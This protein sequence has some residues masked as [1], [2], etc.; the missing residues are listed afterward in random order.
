MYLKLICLRKA[1]FTTSLEDSYGVM[2]QA[3]NPYEELGCATWFVRAQAE[4]A[5]LHRL[6]AWWAHTEGDKPISLGCVPIEEALNL[7]P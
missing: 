3:F 2:A 6:A 7:G 1:R 4:E 5:H